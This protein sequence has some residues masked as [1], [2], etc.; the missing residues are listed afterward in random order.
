M[1]IPRLIA[2]ALGARSL[3]A[4]QIAVVI[5][6]RGAGKTWHALNIAASLTL[7]KH[8]LPVL[9]FA[10]GADKLV[11]LNQL[12]AV[13]KS[14]ELRAAPLFIETTPRLWPVE[15]WLIARRIDRALHRRGT[16]LGLIIVDDLHRIGGLSYDHRLSDLAFLARD[17]GRFIIVLSR[18]HRALTLSIR[19]QR[20]EHVAIARDK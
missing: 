13:W 12:R 3:R 14:S 5:G 15:M 8:P 16:R 2:T 17:L 10:P 6:K 18:P 19:R 7:I 11:L 4:P 1:N 20:V 9:L